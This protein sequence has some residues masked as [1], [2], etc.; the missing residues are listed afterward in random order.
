MTS[1]ASSHPAVDEP[2]RGRDADADDSDTEDGEPS[3]GRRSRMTTITSVDDYDD[4]LNTCTIQLEMD[5]RHCTMHH[6]ICLLVLSVVSIDTIVVAVI[7]NVNVNANFYSAVVA[8]ESE[9]LR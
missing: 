7:H 2:G 9:A 6:G 8:C 4:T 1:L 5:S 3:S